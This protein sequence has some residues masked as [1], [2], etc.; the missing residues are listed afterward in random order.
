MG[1]WGRG[2]FVWEELEEEEE[3]TLVLL[4]SQP[5]AGSAVV[6]VALV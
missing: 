4:L 6:G 3:L 5:G 1:A 2:V